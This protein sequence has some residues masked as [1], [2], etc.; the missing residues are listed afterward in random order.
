MLEAYF[1]SIQFTISRS[2]FRT[3]SNWFFVKRKKKIESSLRLIKQELEKSLAL[4]TIA[5]K[6]PLRNGSYFCMNA[7]YKNKN[8]R[9]STNSSLLHF[10]PRMRNSQLE[11]ECRD[12]WI[13][14]Q[15]VIELSSTHD[16]IFFRNRKKVCGA[17]SFCRWFLDL[18]LLFTFH[19]FF[20]FSFSHS[21][22]GRTFLIKIKTSEASNCSACSDF[23]C[24]LNAW[25]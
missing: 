13:K 21:A 12:N 19:I 16:I 25:S 6:W 22:H 4:V 10:L 18:I 24:I 7:Q 20:L 11:N 14:F 8:S 5:L 3:R 23:Y 1:K 9:N 17:K 15:A 2:E